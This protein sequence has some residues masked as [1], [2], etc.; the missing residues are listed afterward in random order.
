MYVYLHHFDRDNM[1]VSFR[2]D[3][4]SHDIAIK[5][6]SKIL[7]GPVKYLSIFPKLHMLAFTQVQCLAVSQSF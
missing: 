3:R 6:I 7:N 1:R 5:N 2:K 4:F